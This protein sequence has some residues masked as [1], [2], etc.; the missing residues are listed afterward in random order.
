MRYFLAKTDPETYSLADLEREKKTVWDGVKN[1]QALKAIREMKPGDQVFV[2]HSGGE[3]AVVGLA[4]VVSEPRPDPKDPKLAVVDLAYAGRISPP[5]TL[6]EIK[7]SGKFSDWAL[8]RQ[9]RLSTMTVPPA[10]L[11]WI[12]GRL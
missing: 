10:F 5:V 3:S 8:V 1:P 12:R 4:K 7:A 9:G 6:A 2:Y 11:D